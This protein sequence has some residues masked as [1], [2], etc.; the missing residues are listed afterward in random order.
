MQYGYSDLHLRHFSIHFA[1][2]SLFFIICYVI[3]ARNARISFSPGHKI[4]SLPS[5]RFPMVIRMELIYNL[6]I[7][8]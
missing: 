7:I 6:I 2:A 3:I 1:F 8:D 5:N 4:G